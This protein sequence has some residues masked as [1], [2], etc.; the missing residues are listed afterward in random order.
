MTAK[1]RVYAALNHRQPDKIPYHIDFTYKAHQKMAE[2]L[3]DPDFRSKLNNCLCSLSVS[4][5][6]AWI[7]VAPDIWEDEFGVKWNREIDKDIGVVCN[8]RITPETLDDY[9]FPD[10]HDASRYE[11]YPRIIGKSR[12]KF[13]VANIGFSLFER[14]WTLAGMETILMSMVANPDFVH[15][16]LDRIVAYNLNIIDHACEYNVDAMMFGDDWGQQSGL[17]MG[18]KHWREF[19]KPRVTQMYQRVKAHK[20]F[21]FIHSCGRVSELF[22]ELIE[23]GLDVFNPFQ[24]EVMD[25]F[26]MKRRYGASLS[27]FGGIST[28]KMLPFD[29]PQGVKTIVQR[30]ID[31]I[32]QNG[33]YI[34][35][36]AHAIPGD[37]KPENILAMIEVLENQ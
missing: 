15:Q 2:Y 16:L 32:G 35:A 26:E 10:A 9:Q 12:D 31:E 25:V 27:F 30:L 37:A 22:P 14:A 21:V 4:K 34:A 28:Q 11:N 17:I 18:P 3:G 1:E 6:N 5:R 23:A 7:E 19:I 33:G 8:C 24:P 29:T 20:K 13:I 36:P